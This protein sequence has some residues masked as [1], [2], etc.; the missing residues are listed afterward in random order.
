MFIKVQ[1]LSQCLLT[2]ILKSNTQCFFSSFFPA[3]SKFVSKR[4]LLYV[5]YLIDKKEY[6]KKKL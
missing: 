3:F 2:I 1:F 5:S 4:R 6:R